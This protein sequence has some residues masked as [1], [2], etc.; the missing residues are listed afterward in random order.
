MGENPI[1]YFISMVYLLSIYFALKI[2]KRKGV[3]ENKL[4][5]FIIILPPLALVYVLMTDKRDT[6]GN[7]NISIYAFALLLLI[8]TA[9]FVY[10]RVF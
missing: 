4:F 5:M 2:S 3:L 6:E 10:Q 9:L 7:G 1:L 8:I